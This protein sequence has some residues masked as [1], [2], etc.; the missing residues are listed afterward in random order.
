MRCVL[1]LRTWI[2]HVKCLLTSF[3]VGIIANNRAD[4]LA[5]LGVDMHPDDAINRRACVADAGKIVQV[6]Q[7]MTRCLSYAIDNGLYKDI[8]QDQLELIRRCPVS[9]ILRP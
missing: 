5:K 7:Y 9:T 3:Q 4:A 6:V 1:T 8:Q 2:T